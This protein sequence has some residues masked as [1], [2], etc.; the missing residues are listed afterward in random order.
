ML[1]CAPGIVANT[2]GKWASRIPD[3]P[4]D[5]SN[6][7]FGE[8]ITQWGT[9]P[10]GVLERLQKPVTPADIQRARDAG[11]SRD[12]FTAWRDRYLETAS[13]TQHSS[14]NTPKYRAELMQRFI[15]AWD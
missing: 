4:A 14:V 8:E 2:G 6:A 12:H 13:K 3:H 7:R 11:Y 10:S 15:D 9:K 5:F 1:S